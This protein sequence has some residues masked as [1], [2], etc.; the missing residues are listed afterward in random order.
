MPGNI[1]VLKCCERGFHTSVCT[2]DC[3]VLIYKL[4]ISFFF[5]FALVLILNNCN[6]T[7]EGSIFGMIS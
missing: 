7:V 5:F 4:C 3:S 6:T 2:W 1:C